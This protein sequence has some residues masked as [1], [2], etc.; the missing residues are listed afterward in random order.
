[1]GQQTFDYKTYLGDIIT[2]N[3]F[4][5]FNIQIPSTLD[6]IL[7]APNSTKQSEYQ[8]EIKYNFKAVMTA[9]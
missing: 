7:L 3:K 6:R 5:M 8:L 4:Y 9:W 2:E 1:M